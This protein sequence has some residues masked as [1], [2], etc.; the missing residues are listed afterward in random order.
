[1][2]SDGSREAAAKVTHASTESVFPL[3]YMT[4]LISA[5]LEIPTVHKGLWS[6]DTHAAI[7]SGR[8]GVGTRT[9]QERSQVLEELQR[10]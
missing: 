1:M 2:S 7:G 10:F 3:I 6:G 4:G 5:E 8:S 9:S